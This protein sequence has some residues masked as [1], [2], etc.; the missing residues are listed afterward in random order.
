MEAEG[1]VSSTTISLG[2]FPSPSVSVSEYVEQVEE[3]GER[4]EEK[5]ML[6]LEIFI[7][8]S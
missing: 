6:L 5:E 4:A 2:V 3:K 8:V 1:E 7:K